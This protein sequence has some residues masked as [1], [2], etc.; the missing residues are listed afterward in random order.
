MKWWRHAGRLLLW[1]LPV[2]FLFWLYADGLK[3]W[4]VADDFA[5]LGLIRN[6]GT[7]RELL[8]ALFSPAA[9]G[10]IRPW[11]ERGFFLLFESLFGLDSL[12][13][14]ICVFVTAAADLALVNWVTR[15]ITGS[16][17]AGFLAAILWTANAALVTVMAWSSAY[18]EVLCPLFLL[19]A[20]ALFMRYAETG[21]SSFW[22]WQLVVFTLGFGALEVN[23]VYPAL[24]AAYVL[25][26][27]KES[28]RRKLLFSLI[29]LF[30][31]SIVYF[32]IHRALAPLPTRGPYAVHLDS[33]IFPTLALYWKWS[34]L[35]TGWNTL[36]HSARTGGAF[37]WLL[38]VALAAFFIVQVTKSRHLVCFF[39]AWFLI[40][41]APMIP[42]PDHRTDYYLTI[43]LIGLAMLGGDACAQ[44]SRINVRAKWMWRAVALIVLAVYLRAMVPVD[45][46]L[47]RWWLDRTKPVRALVLGVRAAHETHPGKSIVLDGIGSLLYDDSF[48]NSAFYPLGFTNVY[49]V[50]QERD[51][52]RDVVNSARLPAQVIDP[53]SLWRG[54]THDQ[55]VIYSFLG[56]HLRNVTK[57]WARLDSGGHLSSNPA[58]D[59]AP[60]RVD[61]GNP[62]LEYL[63]GS[64][65]YPAEP[66]GF[67][68]MSQRATV[69]LGGP[70]VANDKLLLEGYCTAAQLLA[71]PL[72]LI[73]SVDGVAL[74][75]VRLDGTET[76]FRRLLDV[77]AS[78]V[79]RAGV[80][81]SIAVD[82]VF[83]ETGGR[84]LGLVFGTIAF[85]R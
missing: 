21:R 72:H 33:R 27:A 85:E 28:N 73:V 58:L 57:D 67:R 50:P 82:R 10:T 8:G 75:G 30:C 3:T 19:S 41:L 25:F 24:A 60:R 64:G 23:V 7:T 29:P 14:R 78:V 81:V 51:T 38:T 76:Q 71:G 26:V 6:V 69:R 74:Q 45:R 17:I 47:I 31:I 80:E 16:S 84:E 59:L 65:W 49:L 48:G 34:M 15:R 56:D 83:H 22:W 5:W 32:L 20:L 13:F 4:F 55:V 66:S 79:G 35:P 1:L 36:G 54:I 52:L 12:P 44:A 9:Q 43:P 39:A 53:A 77:P 61:A 40:T 70:E 68:W 37:V 11:S 62:L 46:V 63:L 42:L 2:V 18:N